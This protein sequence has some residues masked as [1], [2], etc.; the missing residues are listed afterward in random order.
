MS[1]TWPR[2]TNVVWSS[3]QVSPA[4]RAALLGH[5]GFT[6]WFTGLSGS[7]KSTLAHGLERALIDRGVLASVLDGDNIRQGLSGDLNF[8][9]ADRAENIRRVG[10]VA[11]VMT[12]AGTAVIA[13]FISPYAE[14]R[15]RVR[16]RFAD[17]RFLEVHVSCPLEV[18]E[19][20]DPKG[21][22]IRARAG[23]IANFTGVSAP[24]EEPHD[25]DHVARTDIHTP[26]QCIAELLEALERRE[27][28]PSGTLGRRT[29]RS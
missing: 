2:S 5:P 29:V 11:V 1:R 25:A 15:A 20:R 22:Y 18:C 14:D 13:A 23:E 10:E 19:Q 9:A 21:L 8:N 26:Q 12:D 28:I 4:E 16:A 3:S 17:G 6:V 7:G 27:W 24:Y